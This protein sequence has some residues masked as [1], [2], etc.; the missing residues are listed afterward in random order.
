M[1]AWPA[2]GRTKRD[3]RLL[4]GVATGL[5]RVGK[6]MLSTPSQVLRLPVL[7]VVGVIALAGCAPPT[8][9]IADRS[10]APVKPK[11]PTTLTL[12]GRLE[13]VNGLAVFSKQQSQSDVA[14][15]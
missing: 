14:A 11:P 5:N 7:L 13:S 4:L 1:V 9:Q 2:P 15:I 8:V 10:A 6:R 3:A 12:S